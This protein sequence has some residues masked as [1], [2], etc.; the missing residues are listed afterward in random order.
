[1]SSIHFRLFV[2]VIVVWLRG[3]CGEGRGL[4]SGSPAAAPVLLSEVPEQLSLV[5]Q[6]GFSRKVRFRFG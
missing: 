1:M 4:I 5:L 3:S 2:E 6:L